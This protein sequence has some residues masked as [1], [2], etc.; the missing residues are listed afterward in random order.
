VD[1][2]FLDAHGAFAQERELEPETDNLLEWTV[3]D[4]YG[5]ECARVVTTQRSMRRWSSTAMWS[6]V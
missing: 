5:R 3:C 2:A 1:E 6:A 4:G